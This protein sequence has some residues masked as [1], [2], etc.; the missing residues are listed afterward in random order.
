MRKSLGIVVS[1]IVLSSSCNEIDKLTQFEIDYNESVVISSATGIDLPV[2]IYT[3]D[4]ESDADS[5]FEVNDT[6][7]DLIEHIS[8]K[9]MQLSIT[10]PD[11]EDFSF[12]KSIRIYISSEGLDEMEIAWK[13]NIQEEIVLDLETSE[14]DIQD[15]IKQDSF[16]LRLN[17]VTDEIITSDYHID[18]KSVFFVD[19]KILGI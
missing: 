15:Y 3:P 2:N 13:E 5:K 17:T 16:S 4:I 9:S 19:A 7:K 14:V 12:L 6:R 18:V 1:I 10:A 8:L 11:G